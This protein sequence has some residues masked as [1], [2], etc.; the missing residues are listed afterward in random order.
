MANKSCLKKHKHQLHKTGN[1]E[2]T[3]IPPH[4]APFVELDAFFSLLKK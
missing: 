1:D 3:R 2:L 4:Q